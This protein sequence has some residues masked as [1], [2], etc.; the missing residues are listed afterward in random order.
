M[1]CLSNEYTMSAGKCE[2]CPGG[3]SVGSVIGALV[4]FMGLFF[5][6]FVLLFMK[7]KRK[8]K[9]DKKKKKGCC[10]KKKKNEDDDEEEEE[11]SQKD[12]KKGCCGKKKKKKKKKPKAE[13][14]EEEKISQKNSKKAIQVVLTMDQALIGR[15]QG[16]SGDGTDGAATG[17]DLRSDPAVIIDR[18]KIFYG[19]LQIFTALTFTFDIQWPIQLRSFSVGLNFINLDLGNILAGSTC[20]YAV[21]YLEKMAVHAAFPLMLLVTIFAA[22]IPAHFLRKKNRKKQHALMIKMIFSLALIL[23]P[24]NFYGM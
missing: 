9:K 17:A 19:W 20:S 1:S 23:Y 3:S 21:P 2:L 18:I 13:K 12:E 14:T 6:I 24:G 7:A 11:D 22:R 16:R 15:M 4:G 10:G 8:E 5:V